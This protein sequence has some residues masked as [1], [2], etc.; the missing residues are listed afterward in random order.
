[1]EILY[2]SSLSGY[3]VGVIYNELPITG[4]EYL[5]KM[6][7]LPIRLP[8]IDT[9]NVREFLEECSAGWMALIDKKYN[10]EGLRSGFSRDEELD[11]KEE[12]YISPCPKLL[13]FFAKS[14]PPKPRKIKRVALLFESKLKLLGDMSYDV[15]LVAKVTLLEL[16]AP[17]LLRF[18]QNNG[19]TTIY[20]RLC[21]FREVEHLLSKKNQEKNSDIILNDLA[22]TP[23]IEKYIK[24]TKTDDLSAY[25]QKEQDVLLKVMGIVQEH[26]SSRITFDLDYIFTEKID[27]SKLKLVMELQ[28]EQ[29]KNI[30]SL[31]VSTSAFSEEMLQKLFRP[32]DVDAW[33]EALVEYDAQIDLETLNNLIIDAQ[34]KKDNTFNDLPFIA[35]PEWVGEVAK[36]VSDDDYLELLNASHNARFKTNKSLD[37]EIDMFQMTFAEYDRYCEI[38]KINKLKDYGWG[39]GRRPLIYVSWNNAYGYVKWLNTKKIGIYKLPSS[40]EWSLACLIFD[41][42]IWHIEDEDDVL[43]LTEYAWYDKNSYGKTHRVGEK[44]PNACGLYDTYGNV[45]EWCEDWED[46]QY[47]DDAVYKMIQGGSWSTSVELMQKLNFRNY[48]EISNDNIGFRLQRTLRS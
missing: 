40:K 46:V 11:V 48:P 16:F 22:D 3:H 35:N 12:F 10:P 44:K 31:K 34:K 26:Y 37:F 45:W 25:T 19:Y 36:Y 43:D 29:S 1:M 33:R 6:I 18:I 27:A 5:E 14:I 2:P 41:Q 4:H 9:V 28:E 15:E 21:H 38:E 32:G 39:R 42:D 23:T 13:D 47:G 30:E 20:N 24:R 8:V 17:K 7:Q